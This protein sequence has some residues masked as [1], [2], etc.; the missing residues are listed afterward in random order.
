MFN[1]LFKKLNVG[2][3]TLLLIGVAVGIIFILL[4]HKVIQY[5]STDKFCQSCHVHP[6]AEVSWKQSTHF[7]NKSGVQVHC[8][9][10]HLPPEGWPYLRE[11][12]KTGSRD[13]WAKLF[14]DTKKINWEE[15][16][17]LENA[18]HIVYKESCIHC[19]QNLF[20]KGLTKEGED[21][22][23]YYTQH[24]K[25]L[26]CINC[27]LT[28]GHF[29]PNAMHAKN[30]M[31]GLTE[32]VNKELYTEPTK[33]NKFENFTE[34]IP[35]STISFDMVAIPGGSFEMGSKDNEPLR[36]KDEGPIRTV[37]VSQ[38]FI[39][40]IEV[41]WDEY[42]AFFKST[43]AEG[44]LDPTIV[45]EKNSKASSVDAISGPTPP[46]GYPDQGWGKGKRP[47]ITMS[48]NAAETYVKWLS[49]ATGK[50]YRLPTE[51]EWEYA[52]RGGKETPYFFEGSPK[53][54]SDKGF[55]KKIFAPDT[56]VIGRYVAYKLNSA[57][58]SQES[59][60]VKANPFG[61]LNMLGNVREF[62]ADW[63]DADYYAKSGKSVV[64]PKGPE[65]GTDHVVRGGSFKSDASD[66]RVASRDYTRN[67]AWLKTDPQM[68]KSIWWYSDVTD[69]GFRV[70]CEPDSAIKTSELH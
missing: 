12:I 53:K 69:V 1:R 33:I 61:L 10:C 43:A 66:V 32:I 25:D 15:K 40:K 42:M 70:V 23:L 37:K 50:K 28:V 52:A 41:T 7:T 8:V 62:C 19:H 2:V 58:K 14:T 67:D 20:T 22:H 3:K 36:K 21:A 48:Y 16:G 34:K 27:H 68:P 54:Y 59:G 39:G 24:E 13:V 4:S 63:Y 31:F 65:S 26:H 38:F 17:K 29:N 11:K 5:T 55:W 46:Y 49:M 60:F 51:A 35:G 9:E 47:A 45:M 56:A 18:V 64:D 44:R 6:H 30:K 57:G